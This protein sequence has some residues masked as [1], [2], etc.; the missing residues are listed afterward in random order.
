VRPRITRIDANRREFCPE[1]AGASPA[2]ASP[3][4]TFGA[5][6]ETIFNRCRAVTRVKSSERLREQAARLSNSVAC[7]A[8][9][10]LRRLSRRIPESHH[11]SS[12]AQHLNC[13]PG[14]P[15]ARCSLRRSQLQYP[16]SS[17][18]QLLVAP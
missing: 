6:A 8:V 16:P 2:N 11:E 17:L 4:R 18:F 12:P 10:L 14:S 9:A 13:F 1:S 15:F 5:L 3:A 7:R